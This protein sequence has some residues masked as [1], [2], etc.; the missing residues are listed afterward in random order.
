MNQCKK[1]F[2]TISFHAAGNI[3]RYYYTV[4]QQLCWPQNIDLT[5]K[6]QQQMFNLLD[7]M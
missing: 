3:Q 4:Q 1:E 2:N 7:S 6:K 5:T